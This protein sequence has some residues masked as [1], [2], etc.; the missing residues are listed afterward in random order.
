MEHHAT[1][2]CPDCGGR[3]SKFVEQGLL[4]E[5]RTSWV[6]TKCKAVLKQRSQDNYGGAALFM[7][8]PNE[9]EEADD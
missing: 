9:K 7:G 5:N 2:E 3:I 1:N 4:G 6:C 8:A